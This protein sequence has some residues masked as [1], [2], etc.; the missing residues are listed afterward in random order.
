MP[1]SEELKESVNLKSAAQADT[2]QTTIP[3][4]GELAATMWPL[5]CLLF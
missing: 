3:V 4:N 5:F 1:G 2:I